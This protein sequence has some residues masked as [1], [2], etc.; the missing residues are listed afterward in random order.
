MDAW[1]RIAEWL[2]TQGWA[3]ILVLG[4]LAVIWDQRKEITFLRVRNSTLQDARVT[5]AKSVTREMVE[6]I[7]GTRQSVQTLTELMK[8]RR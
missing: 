3:G 8:D 6:T 1:P 4:M 2:L 5:D 7:T